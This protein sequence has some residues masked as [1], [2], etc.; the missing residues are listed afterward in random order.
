[1]TLPAKLADIFDEQPLVT[2]VPRVIVIKTGRV[3]S[4]PPTI[5]V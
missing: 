4:M 2:A 3:L 5:D 1:L